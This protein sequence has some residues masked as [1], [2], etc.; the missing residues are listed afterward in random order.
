MNLKNT[1]I[2]FLLLIISIWS[3][4]QQLNVVGLGHAGNVKYFGSLGIEY[5]TAKRSFFQLHFMGGNFGKQSY[6]QTNMINS[7]YIDA[8]RY[9]GWWDYNQTKMEIDKIGLGAQ[10][11]YGFKVIKREKHHVELLV[12]FAYYLINDKN[13]HEFAATNSLVLPSIVQSD[14]RS[15]HTA[16]NAGLGLN[17]RFLF[18]E[19][20]YFNAGININSFSSFE[21]GKYYPNLLLSD[22]EK[23]SLPLI[24][25]EP[26]LHL[27]LIYKVK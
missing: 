15:K 20:W 3:E 16:F 5:Q 2:T 17:Y 4:A 13:Y 9:G 18:S 14:F 1:V 24:G 6:D 21:G 25:I 26:T 8:N 12:N 11:G 27:G 22:K 7:P 23:Y 19:K 10:L